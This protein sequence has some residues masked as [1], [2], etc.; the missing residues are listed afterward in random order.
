MLG[1][2]TPNTLPGPHLQE[3]LPLL[4]EEMP[5]AIA[6]YAA[7]LREH[8]P[9]WYAGLSD[10]A[11]ADLVGPTLVTILNTL[12]HGTQDRLEDYFSRTAH[13]KLG[14]GIPVRGVVQAMML[15]RTALVD[16]LRRQIPDAVYL[17]KVLIEFDRAYNDMVVLSAERY[18][19]MLLHK[20]EA[21]HDCNERL[22][23]VSRT[24]SGALD[25]DTVLERMAQALAET[26]ENGCCT[27]FLVEPESGALMPRA[28]WGYDSETHRRSI[29]GLRLCADG[30]QIRMRNGKSFG[31]SP[32]TPESTLFAAQIPEAIR[33]GWLNF[34]PISNGSNML[35]AALLSSRLSC[36]SMSEETA[37]QVEAILNSLAMAIENAASAQRTKNRLR[38]SEGLRRVANRLLQRPKNA[39]RDVFTLICDETRKI[40][41]G[42]GSAILLFESGVL[43]LAHGT[44]SPLPPMHTFGRHSSRYGELFNKGRSVIIKDAQAELPPAERSD[45]T[46]TVAVVPLVGGERKMGLLLV[47]NKMT[48]FDKED[49]RIIELFGTQAVLALRNARLAVQNEM[50]AV[51]GERQRLARELHDSVTQALY[52]ANLCADAAARS[53]QA[54]K[55]EGASGQLQS[56][57]CMTRQAMRDMRTLIF[58]LHPPELS[59]EGLV[60]ALQSRLNS[61]E[62]R[63]G[64]N[65]E[66]HV[67][68]RERRLPPHLEEELFRIAIE[69]LNNTAKHSQAEQVDV[70]LHFDDHAVSL[71]IVDNG[72]GFEPESVPSGGIGM[73]GMRERAERISATVTIQ[74]SPGQGTSILVLA[75]IPPQKD[76]P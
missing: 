34:F 64:L 74:S 71:N 23:K 49:I 54:G 37:S 26:V 76:T 46:Q 35:G 12:T 10:E 22:L 3:A 27:I 38:E 62:G 7:L 45:D 39:S 61:V 53:L 33:S 17:N 15:S 29:A 5:R 65:P 63:S 44:G 36:Y 52:A 47:F 73:R 4:R 75:P 42:T 21:E 72:V 55:L 56:L 14:K 1:E 8:Q 30:T 43:H 40:I 70:Q 6:E 48:G 19:D 67:E 32:R 2:A 9:H 60:G 66:L 25:P 24:I 41:G 11:L 28:T 31:F 18:S 59:S 69:A 16:A 50:L 68:G 57:R 13:Y 20:L 51:A 58:D